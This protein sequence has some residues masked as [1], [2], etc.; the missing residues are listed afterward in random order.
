MAEETIE[1]N[2]NQEIET[3]DIE[4]KVEQ[5]IK[6]RVSERPPIPLIAVFAFEVLIF[7]LRLNILD[8]HMQ[9]TAY[10]LLYIN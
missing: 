2:E 6:Y 5:Y 4:C 8:S 3:V 9:K 1:L 10:K 7:G